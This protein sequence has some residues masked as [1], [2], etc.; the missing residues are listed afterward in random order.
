MGLLPAMFLQ[1]YLTNGDICKCGHDLK[2]HNNGNC[3]YNIPKY[4]ADCSCIMFTQ[5]NY[6]NSAKKVNSKEILL[7]VEEQFRGD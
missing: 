4:F 1:G 6:V 5:K 3:S 2:F 7:N